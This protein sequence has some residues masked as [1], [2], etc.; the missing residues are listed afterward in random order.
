MREVSRTF[1]Y[2]GEDVKLVFN[3][4]AMQV[5]QEEYGTLGNWGELTDGKAEGEPNIKALIFG[6]RAMLNEAIEIENEDNG[7]NKPLYT[8]RQVGRILT[9]VGLDNAS[10]AVKET[11]IKSTKDPEGDSKNA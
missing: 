2:K 11:V 1:K 5:I 4:N 6:M 10:D 7:T 8:E 9:E 3:L